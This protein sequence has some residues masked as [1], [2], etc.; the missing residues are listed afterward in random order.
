M[1]NDDPESENACEEHADSDFEKFSD[2]DPSVDREPYW[3]KSFERKTQ[4]LS[5]RFSK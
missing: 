5:L 3:R 1:F 4:I 2:P